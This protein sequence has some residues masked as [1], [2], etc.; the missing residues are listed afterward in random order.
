MGTSQSQLNRETKK[1][2]QQSSCFFHEK[3]IVMQE[4]KRHITLGYSAL[5][6]TYI[7]MKLTPNTGITKSTEFCSGQLGNGHVCG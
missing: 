3:Q 4:K 1:K 6:S 5:S 2:M 7:I